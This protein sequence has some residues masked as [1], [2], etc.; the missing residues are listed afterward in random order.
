MEK[1]KEQLFGIAKEYARQFG[2]LLGMDMEFWVA[3]EPWLCCFGDTYF[4]TLEEMSGVV[5]NLDALVKRH[6]SKEAVGQEIR[7]WVD[8][9]LESGM[10]P[11]DQERVRARV[12]HQL[13]VNITLLAWLKGCP[14]E[15][16]Q[17]FEG[18]DADY[19][20]LLNEHDLLETLIEE[21][22]ENRSLGNVMA[23]VDKRLDIARE[24]KARKDFEY[25]ENFVRN[26]VV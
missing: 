9:W 21:Y 13:R 4:F 7:D 8:W 16:R 26:K 6:G 2:E 24:E 10:K 1:L 15:D 18:P 19:L 25:W 23:A 20:R 5:D 22:R 14:R 3:D 17:P 11:Q 12:T